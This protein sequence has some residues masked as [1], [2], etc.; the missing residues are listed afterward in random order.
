ML[1]YVSFL[2]YFAKLK[3]GLLLTEKLIKTQ[4]SVNK[5]YMLAANIQLISTTAH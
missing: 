1:V 5:N 2:C 4:I 3:K